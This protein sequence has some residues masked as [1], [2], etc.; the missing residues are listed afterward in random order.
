MTSSTASNE[1]DRSIFSQSFVSKK[2]QSSEYDKEEALVQEIP[3]DLESY[4][5]ATHL[6]DVIPPS[7]MKEDSSQ[8]S[9]RQECLIQVEQSIVYSSTWRVPVLYFSAYST[10]EF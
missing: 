1:V 5:E 6:S 10:G 3:D 4:D 2:K 9:L 8:S 7:G